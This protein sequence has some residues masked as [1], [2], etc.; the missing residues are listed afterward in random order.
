MIFYLPNYYI[1][2]KEY[3]WIFQAFILIEM[4]KKMEKSKNI[5]L[6]KTGGKKDGKKLGKILEKKLWRKTIW[7][8][9]CGKRLGEKVV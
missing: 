8:K 7:G 2:K 5:K 6:E 3:D 4:E 9:S 1:Y